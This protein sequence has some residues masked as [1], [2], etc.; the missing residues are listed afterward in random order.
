MPYRNIFVE[1]R[2]SMRLKNNQL[3][4]ENGID[5]FSFPIEDIR[6][7][8]IDNPYSTLSAKLIN[9]LADEGVCLILTNDKHMPSCELIPI[10]SYHRLNKRINLQFNQSKPKLKRI[11]QSIAI[12]K[13]E[14]QAECLRLNNIDGWEKVL[15]I[16]KTVLSGDS[17]NRE[18]YAA[19]IY[20]KMLF[21]SD[22]TRDKENAVN[23]ALNYGY[24]II[25]SF[26]SKTIVCEGLEP[27]LGIHHKNQL[28]QFNLSDDIIEPF[29][30]IVDNYVYNNYIDWGEEFY[31]FQKSELLRLL[32]CKTVVNGNN[33]SLSRAV[34]L[35]VQSIVYSYEE[36]NVDLN[37]PKLIE[38]DFFEYD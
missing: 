19:S 9:A 10:A 34:E 36:D 20:F 32:N 17:T 13:I 22:F 31:R 7:I 25:R 33:C 2:A 35:F 30:P 26:I 1:N 12:A 38:T 3:I 16:S 23:A 27:S 21:G 5:V 14:N 18:G 29:R 28:N 4:V 8:V 24:S 6:S 15:N 37:L 11:W